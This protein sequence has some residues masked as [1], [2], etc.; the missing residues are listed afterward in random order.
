MARLDLPWRIAA[1]V[2]TAAALAGL[3]VDSRAALGAGLGALAA[4]AV[5]L[6]ALAM[7]RRAGRRSDGAQAAVSALGWT[8]ALRLGGG[9]LLVVAA[10]ATGRLAIAPFVLGFFA[11]YAVLEI[12]VDARLIADADAAGPANRGTG[13]AA[14]PH[15]PAEP[16]A[17]T[18]PGSR[19][20]E[21]YESNEE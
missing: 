3:A 18:A 2:V 19:V 9:T 8:F 6:A 10:A 13:R 15:G 7:A 11:A 12:A 17:R 5:Q 14:P 1:L 4:A 16:G 21:S 20:T